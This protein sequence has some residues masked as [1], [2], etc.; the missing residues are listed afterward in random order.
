[1]WCGAVKS[2][3]AAIR[4]LT[5][6]QYSSFRAQIDLQ[7]SKFSSEEQSMPLEEFLKNCP[8]IKSVT[9]ADGRIELQK[10][11]SPY[12]K[13]EE[14]KRNLQDLLTKVNDGTSKGTNSV[15]F[16]P[17]P[18]PTGKISYASRSSKFRSSLLRNFPT[19]LTRVLICW[20]IVFS[21]TSVILPWTEYFDAL[22]L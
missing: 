10:R 14:S 22:V 13:L 8:G 7:L 9:G 3:S 19:Q 4:T 21:L 6:A 1:M 15:L 20:P 16:T 12:P 2:R 11:S 5:A 17:C 18:G